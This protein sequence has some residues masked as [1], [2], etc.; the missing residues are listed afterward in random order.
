MTILGGDCC[1][2]KA[3]LSIDNIIMI[4]VKEVQ[5]ISIDGATL[6]TVIMAMIF[7]I[8]SDISG[9]SNEN[10]SE[11]EVFNGAMIRK[12]IMKKRLSMCF[13]TFSFIS[14]QDVL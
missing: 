4:L 7:S 11:A 6:N 9:K 12:N 3:L 8:F 10:A 13:F 1:K 14:Y 2:P 5:M